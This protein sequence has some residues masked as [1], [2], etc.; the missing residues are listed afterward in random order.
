MVVICMVVGCKWVSNELC[1]INLVLSD[2]V[3][4]KGL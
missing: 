4:I 3:N 2:E 1:I